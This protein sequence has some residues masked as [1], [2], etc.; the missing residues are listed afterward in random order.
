VTTAGGTGSLASAFTVT[1]KETPKSS[2]SHTKI[3]IGVG[4]VAAVVLA[5]GI[6]VYVVRSRRADAKAKRT[7]KR[8]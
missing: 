7:S 6:V 2:N 3:W 4:V 8:K 1:P 5:A